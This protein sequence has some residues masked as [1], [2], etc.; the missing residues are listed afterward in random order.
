[1]LTKTK[2]GIPENYHNI[3]IQITEGL[4][5]G[6]E[7][8]RSA[9]IEAM[10]TL[11]IETIQ[12]AKS[13]LDINSPSKKF[14]YLGEMSGQGYITGWEQT[15]Q[16]IDSIIMDTLPDLPSGSKN[17]VAGAQA[18]TKTI[19]PDNLINKMEQQNANILDVCN[20]MQTMIAKY[21]PQMANMQ[22]V[23][24]TGALIG[25]LMPGLDNEFGNMK[26]EKERGVL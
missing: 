3:G 16:N 9:V 10:R 25:E 23:T 24:N 8:G 2:E 14:E 4:K 22:I 18:A 11:C 6:I 17:N 15:M 21:M 13:T 12:T 5:S 26:T 19:L 1:M 7:A 20:K